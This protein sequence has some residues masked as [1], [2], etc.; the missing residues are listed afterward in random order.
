MTLGLLLSLIIWDLSVGKWH[1][2]KKSAN[3][4]SQIAAAPAA[5]AAASVFKT[6]IGGALPV[7]TLL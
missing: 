4:V 3:K 1:F 2:A 6:E 5:A 7:K